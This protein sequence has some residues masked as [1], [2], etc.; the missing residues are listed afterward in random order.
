MKISKKVAV[1]NYKEFENSWLE[2]NNRELD[3]ADLMVPVDLAKV[4]S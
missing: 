1:F 2:M 4:Y 3:V